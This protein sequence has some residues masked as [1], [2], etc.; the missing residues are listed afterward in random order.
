MR[1]A[2]LALEDGDD[3]RTRRGLVQPQHQEALEITR[4]D[5]FDGA[6]KLLGIARCRAFL[7]DIRVRQTECPGQPLPGIE[8]GETASCK[9]P[10]AC[11]FPAGEERTSPADSPI[12][13]KPKCTLPPTRSSIVALVNQAV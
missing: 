4:A 13:P 7:A 6:R 11:P 12:G 1:D 9:G 2:S 5:A 3:C 8:C 10:D